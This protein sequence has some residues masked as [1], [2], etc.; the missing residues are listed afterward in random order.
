VVVARNLAN[1]VVRKQIIDSADPHRSLRRGDCAGHLIEGIHGSLSGR[2]EV[3][4]RAGIDVS[5]SFS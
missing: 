1:S 4:H 5:K 3:V 2:K